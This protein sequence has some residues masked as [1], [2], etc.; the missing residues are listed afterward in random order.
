MNLQKGSCFIYYRKA[1]W[2]ELIRV[3]YHF[4]KVFVGQI[5]LELVPMVY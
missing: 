2:D 5:W 3:D 1:G 4:I